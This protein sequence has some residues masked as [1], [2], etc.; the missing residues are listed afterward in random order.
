MLGLAMRRRSTVIFG[1]MHW[2]AV[3]PNRQLDDP[4]MKA[5]HGDNGAE[6]C[7]V[8]AH[9][10]AGGRR[11]PL[12]PLLNRLNSTAHECLWRV[13]DGPLVSRLI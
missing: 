5:E 6:R 2:S 9:P 13:S 12:I 10:R 11:E 7:L 4:T 1:L 8:A 3:L